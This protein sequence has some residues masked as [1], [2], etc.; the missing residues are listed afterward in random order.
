M[1]IE[2][3]YSM[4]PQ[5]VQEAV[6]YCWGLGKRLG[7]RL[8]SDDG[9]ELADEVINRVD[10]LPINIVNIVSNVVSHE[11]ACFKIIC[12]MSLADTFLCTTAQDIPAAIVTH[13][14]EITGKAFRSLD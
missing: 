9:M 13:E 1:W 3:K 6:K 10:D 2:I 4:P 14:S 7:S 5:I 8:T 12:L 11:A